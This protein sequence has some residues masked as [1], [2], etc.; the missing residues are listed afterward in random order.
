MGELVPFT[1]KTPT[2]PISPGIPEK[3][4]EIP[5]NVIF[6]DQ[7]QNGKAEESEPPEGKEALSQTGKELAQR[8]IAEAWEIWQNIQ[9]ALS[10]KSLISTEDGWA[11]RRKPN[12][13]ISQVDIEPEENR[14]G[15]CSVRYVEGATPNQTSTTLQITSSDWPNGQLRRER[16]NITQTKRTRA[17]WQEPFEASIGILYDEEGKILTVW[18]KDSEK[19]LVIARQLEKKVA[20][21]LSKS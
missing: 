15:T 8:E 11:Y 2:E 16:V 14:D 4:E 17:G 3:G 9:A 21:K 5:E 7:F 1:G 10:G 12:L 19:G 20:E 18:R 6:P 13:E